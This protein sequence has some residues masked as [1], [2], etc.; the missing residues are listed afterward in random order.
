M[1][2]HDNNCTQASE[3][4]KSWRHH[5]NSNARRSEFWRFPVV[6]QRA[7]RRCRR[8]WGRRSLGWETS[9]RL[10]RVFGCSRGFGFE[11][12]YVNGW[13]QGPLIVEPSGVGCRESPTELRPNVGKQRPNGFSPSLPRACRRCRQ[14]WCRRSL[15]CREC[16]VVAEG[17]VSREVTLTV[18]ARAR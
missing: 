16:S 11:G 2:H 18:G 4:A 6:L 13:C 8:C 12:G 1:N 9:C 3:K 7:C 5:D 10:P 17:L 15:G 14:W